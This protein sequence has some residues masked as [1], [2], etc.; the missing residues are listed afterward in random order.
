MPK[1]YESATGRKRL[2]RT[3]EKN[4]VECFDDL[5]YCCAVTVEDGMLTGGAEPGIDYTRLDLFKL[6]MPLAL[7]MRKTALENGENAGTLITT[8]LPDS[9]PSAGLPP[10]A[11]SLDDLECRALEFLR[12]Q[13]GM[14]S[15]RS[16]HMLFRNRVKNTSSEEVREV[17]RR[18]KIKGALCVA[19]HRSN[20]KDQVISSELMAG[21]GEDWI[22]SSPT[23]A[24]PA[25]PSLNDGK[26]EQAA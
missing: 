7:E 23:A 2:L 13:N 14:L 24:N 19:W 9:Y 12:E 6:A 5:H 21:L 20:G 8:G 11:P 15:M 10:I 1:F 3:H 17:I 16:M 25:N 18:L 22:Q 4:R 26:P